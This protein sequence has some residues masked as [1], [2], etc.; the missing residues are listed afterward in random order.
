MP[1]KSFSKKTAYF[2]L[3]ISFLG[4]LFFRFYI[5][6]DITMS[7]LICGPCFI[8]GV[9]SLVNKKNKFKGVKSS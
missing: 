7:L 3:I 6:S 9:L 2:Y 5:K 4:F 8:V 1:Y